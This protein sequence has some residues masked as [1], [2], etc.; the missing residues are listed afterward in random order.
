MDSRLNYLN[1]KPKEIRWR[2]IT[3]E[4]DLNFYESFDLIY[5]DYDLK[6]RK[7]I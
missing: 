7:L 4:R 5:D 1:N 3:G 6:I 2:V